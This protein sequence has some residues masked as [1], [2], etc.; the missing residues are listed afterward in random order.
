M[1]NQSLILIIFFIFGLTSGLYCCKSEKPSTSEYKIKFEK[2]SNR[3]YRIALEHLAEAK[4]LE[5]ENPEI[6]IT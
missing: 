5:P 1:R 4:R 3:R 6:V 2:D